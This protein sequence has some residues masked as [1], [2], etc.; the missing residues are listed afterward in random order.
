MHIY[1]YKNEY[2]LCVV[3]LYFLK[4]RF[5]AISSR[6]CIRDAFCETFNRRFKTKLGMLIAHQL[7]RTEQSWPSG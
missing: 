4:I 5:K 6:F 1:T 3:S 7:R 2:I